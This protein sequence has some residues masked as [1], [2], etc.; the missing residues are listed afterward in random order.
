MYAY[1]CVYNFMSLLLYIMYNK[2]ILIIKGKTY[3]K[4]SS[5]PRVWRHYL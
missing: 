4:C 5:H 2:N 1:N 3:K